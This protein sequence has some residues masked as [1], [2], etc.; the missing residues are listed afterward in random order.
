VNSCAIKS[1]NEPVESS[2]DPEASAVPA[3]F[4]PL[5]FSV[6]A[7]APSFA[8]PVSVVPVSFPEGACEAVRSAEAVGDAEG[9]VP[10]GLRPIRWL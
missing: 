4:F 2:T 7:L 6:R 5:V 10:V 8:G 1:W 9:L 3:V